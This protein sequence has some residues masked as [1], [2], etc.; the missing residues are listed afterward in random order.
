MTTPADAADHGLLSPQWA[1]LEIAQVTSD[2]AIVHA[3]LDVEVALAWAWEELGFA[4]TGTGQTVAGVREGFDVDVAELAARS[5]S[6]GNPVIPLV[7]DLRSAVAETDAAASVWVHR[8]A[9]SQDILDT[10]LMLV[11][12]RAIR[13]MRRDARATVESL[14]TLAE[15]HR[16]TLMV[17]R[18]LTQHGVPSTFGVKAAGW[19]AGVVRAAAALERSHDALPVQWGGAGGTLSA[20]AVIGGE[21]TGLRVASLVAERLG[22][23][24]SVPWQTQ[25]APVV[26]LGATLAQLAGALGKIAVDVLLLARPELGEL[27]E[28]SAAGRGGSSAMPQKQNPVLSVLIHSAARQ[29][30][31]LAA[32]LQRSALAVDER[33]EGAWHAEWQALRQLLRLGGGAAEAAAELTGG[34]RVYPEAMRHNLGMSG[35]L[36]VSERLMIEYGPRLGRDRL[37]E[38]VTRAAGDADADLGALLRAEPELAEVSDSA[39]AESLDPAHYL[40]DARLI[41]DRVV[42]GVREGG[43]A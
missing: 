18:T 17:S 36:V 41:V 39:L 32:E 1:G 19:L 20:Y 5:R 40:G 2:A 31:G 25:R 21:G 37:Q 26:E 11:A 9:T 29:A 38:L 35:P 43:E 6:G 3:M 30:P 22:L 33:P 42:A 7:K 34:L 12:S 15:T 4:P 23:A 28:P 24:D 14:V 16:D 8:G 13:Q 27:G 10:A